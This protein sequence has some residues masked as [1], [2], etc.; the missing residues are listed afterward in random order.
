MSCF[1]TNV[2]WQ[3]FPFLISYK[4]ESIN[5]QKPKRNFEDKRFGKLMCR[6][7]ILLVVTFIEVYFVFRIKIQIKL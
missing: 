6:R 1:F 3:C 7:K 5:C 2:Y 4:N